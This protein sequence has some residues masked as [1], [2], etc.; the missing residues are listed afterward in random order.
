VPGRRFA[1]IALDAEQELRARQDGAERHLDAAVK[2]IFGS[3]L[4]VELERHRQ[5]AIGD[6]PPVS[7]ASE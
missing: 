5:I 2:T 1:G 4:P 6:W 7:T 3:P